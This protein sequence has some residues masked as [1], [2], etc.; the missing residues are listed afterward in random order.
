MRPNVKEAANLANPN[1]TT[2]E[3][4]E[5]FEA[6]PIDGGPNRDPNFFCYELLR[7]GLSFDGAALV[8]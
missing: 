3:S 5:P 1:L 6:Q 2:M 4:E 7:G 8:R